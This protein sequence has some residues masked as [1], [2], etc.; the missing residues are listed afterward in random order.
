MSA[1]AAKGARASSALRSQCQLQQVSR[2]SLVLF[3]PDLACLL[4][5]SCLTSSCLPAW[6][7]ACL[8]LAALGVLG[9][10]GVRRSLVGDFGAMF[11]PARATFRRAV[12]S[13]EVSQ[14]FLFGALVRGALASPVG[15]FLLFVCHS[16]PATCR[17]PYHNGESLPSRSDKRAYNDIATVFP[18]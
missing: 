14:G 9:L 7:S 16:R 10:W 6:P 5:L 3:S 2:L 1:I 18:K 8:L 4:L 15:S 13:R 17:A 11:G 12:A